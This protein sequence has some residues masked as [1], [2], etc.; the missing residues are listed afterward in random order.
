MQENTSF[1][2]KSNGG[3]LRELENAMWRK[4]FLHGKDLG[5][6][7]RKLTYERSDEARMPR[8]GLQMFLAL[9][10]QIAFHNSGV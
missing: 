7:F 2:A 6:M 5:L 4:K 10:S 1:Y 3:G 8:L 9:P